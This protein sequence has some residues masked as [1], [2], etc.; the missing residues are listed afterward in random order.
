M[1]VWSHSGEYS[2]LGRTDNPDPDDL[3][4]PKS[5]ELEEMRSHVVKSGI[6]ARLED[7]EEE[8]SSQSS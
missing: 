3:E 6:G 5:G 4:S 1:S 7:S 2:R 8:E